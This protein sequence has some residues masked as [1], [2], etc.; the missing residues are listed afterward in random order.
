MRSRFMWHSFGHAGIQR[1]ATSGHSGKSRGT[2]RCAHAWRWSR[3][4]TT[5]GCG[6][7]CRFRGLGHTPLVSTG[8]RGFQAAS[9]ALQAG[10]SSRWFGIPSGPRSQSLLRDHRHRVPTRRY[11]SDLRACRPERP[12]RDA[13]ATPPSGT[14]RYTRSWLHATLPHRH[15]RRAPRP[16]PGPPRRGHGS[17]RHPRGQSE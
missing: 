17:V 8:S 5:L 9:A 6:T 7:A 2:P 15:H 14:V 12:T 13:E 3:F 16:R 11:P 1:S 4:R 10:S